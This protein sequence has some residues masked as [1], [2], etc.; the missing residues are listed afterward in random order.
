M[1]KQFA[2]GKTQKRNSISL[3][4]EMS[5]KTTDHSYSSD[6]KNNF[7]KSTKTSSCEAVKN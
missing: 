3:L 7:F 1:K 4:W 5:I 6:Q 2:K